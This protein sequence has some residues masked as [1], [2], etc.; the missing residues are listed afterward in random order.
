MKTILLALLLFVTASLSMAEDNPPSKPNVPDKIEQVIIDFLD[1]TSDAGK[2]ITN[3]AGQV[4]DY[5]VQEIPII[6][7]EYMRWY[8][9]KSIILCL[10]GVGFLSISA[11]LFRFLWKLLNSDRPWT[12]SKNSYTSEITNDGLLGILSILFGL[13]LII[14]GFAFTVENLD[15][16]QI[17]IA[18]RVYLID[19]FQEKMR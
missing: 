13:L 5:A 4:A 10:V 17:S 15:W 2:T 8:F 14:P 19:Q 11:L 9:W 6:V 16:V 7:Q 18:P 3:A 12:I 1:A